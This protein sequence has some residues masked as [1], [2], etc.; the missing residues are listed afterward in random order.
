MNRQQPQ[1]V[2]S[3]QLPKR[4]KWYIIPRLQNP[5]LECFG[6]ARPPIITVTDPFHHP[7]PNHL[8]QIEVRTVWRP[9][10]QAFKL[11]GLFGYL[12]FLILVPLVVHALLPYQIDDVFLLLLGDGVADD[13][14]VVVVVTVPDLIVVV[15]VGV[16]TVQTFCAWL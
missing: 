3:H 8:D 9:S 11:T 1:S 10:R 7:T 5:F 15:F 14:D 13:V 4:V 12:G 2:R 16:V 6:V